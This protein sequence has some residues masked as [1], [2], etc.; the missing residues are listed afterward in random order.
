MKFD[1]H[2]NSDLQVMK[3]RTGW[4]VGYYHQEDDGST[5]EYRMSGFMPSPEQAAMVLNDVINEARQQVA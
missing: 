2:G 3:G 5:T 4:Y 1:A